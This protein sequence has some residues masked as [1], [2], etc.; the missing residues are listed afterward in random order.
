MKLVNSIFLASL[1]ATISLTACDKDNNDPN[2]VVPSQQDQTFIMQANVS[3]TSEVRLG[4]L[5]AAKGTNTSVKAYGQFMVQEHTQAQLDLKRT[6][7]NVGMMLNDTL[8]A[9]HMTLMTQLNA[10]SGRA[11]DSAY[12]KS[13]S[14][15]HAATAAAFQTEITTG[16]NY[17]PRAY[18]NTYLPHVQ[19]HK[20]LADSIYSKL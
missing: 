1:M 8:D 19:Q 14:A 7:M 16:R 15:D 17:Y 2:Y 11:F 5:A 3:N 18:A 13:Q 4:Q 9:A 20:I 12:L 10:L 6:A